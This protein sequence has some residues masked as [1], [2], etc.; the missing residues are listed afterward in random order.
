MFKKT[1]PNTY[2][3]TCFLSNEETIL[4]TISMEYTVT[5]YEDVRSKDAFSVVKP[6]CQLF[7][8]TSSQRINLYNPNSQNL[9]PTKN[10]TSYLNYPA[11]I[12]T[13][14]YLNQVD[15]I[16]PR[17]LSYSPETVNTQVQSSGAS[18][19]S[20]GTS[21]GNS[22]STTSGSTIS[23]TNT[24]GASV[25]V[26]DTFSGATASYEHS[27]TV[28][29]ENSSTKAT[30]TAVNNSV[31]SQNAAS[32]SIKD[33]GAFALVNPTTTKPT[34]TFGQEYPWDAIQ[35]KDSNGNS[36]PYNN[37]QV[38][39]VIP[40]FML[41]RLY[42]QAA[43]P[44]AITL[45][46][47][48]ELSRFGI[49]FVM[50]ASWIV[51]V[52]NESPTELTIDHAVNYFSASHIL[53][54]ADTVSV[55]IDQHES[56]LQATGNE[57]LST[58]ID[59]NFMALD[60]LGLRGN[61]AIIGFIP[62]KFIKQPKPATETAAPH[63]FKIIST[64]NDLLIQDTTQYPVPCDIGAGFTASQ[65]SLNAAFSTNCLSL[66]LTLYFKVIDSTSNYI[67]YMKHWKSKATG[68]IL[69]LVINNDTENPIIKYI[70]AIE[71]EG[72][73]NNLLQIALRNQDF[74]SVDYHDY[75]QLG[76]NAI[77]ITIQ[78][79]DNDYAQCEYQIRAVSIE[80]S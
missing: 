37:D 46:P 14:I 54:G 56:I 26:G 52:N 28:A 41:A 53:G 72:G 80:Q 17:L 23:Q 9:Q 31:D 33:W 78:P 4:G 49:N 39:L 59:L 21:I 44:K 58:S 64:T 27:S 12:N 30:S 55:Y 71:A 67:L 3:K 48:S 60:P 76:L 20:N 68:L 69:T 74:A 15:G 50:N 22:N 16:V 7:I 34:W 47:P 38:Q 42:G 57:S 45:Y 62:S 18:T 5:L 10:L 19:D 75:L 51:E 63:A 61:A 43:S 32:M 1:D 11:M 66:Q 2:R 36:N 40:A 8:V 73:E 13:S 25:T 65:T 70:D 29:S 24:Y 79:F 35:C 77:Q 6:K